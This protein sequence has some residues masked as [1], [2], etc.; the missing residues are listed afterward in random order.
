MN[1]MNWIKVKE[2]WKRRSGWGRGGEG[3]RGGGGGGGGRIE[4]KKEQPSEF[5]THER[6][7]FVTSASSFA[8]CT[9]IFE[10]ILL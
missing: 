5:Q 8:F 1:G 7:I 10:W 3:G 4:Q 2:N 6:W 9:Y